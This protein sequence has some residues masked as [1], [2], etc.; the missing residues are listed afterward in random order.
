[1]ANRDKAQK[2][3]QLSKTAEAYRLSFVKNV[4][5]LVASGFARLD[6][7]KLVSSEEPDITGLLVDA[8]R[9]YVQSP[10][11][12][13]WAVH[14]AIHDDPPLSTGV[15]LGKRRPRVDIEFER[16]QAGK[17]P[18]FQFEAKRLYI[19][20]GVAEY[21]GKDGLGCF[22]SGRYAAGHPDAGMLGYVQSESV[23]AWTVKVQKGLDNDRRKFRIKVNGPIW[24]QSKFGSHSVYCSVH[25]RRSGP[26]SVYHSFLKCC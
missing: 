17:R 19:H 22:I 21:T 8:I 13:A 9:A 26:I 11:A 3:P 1:M 7:P 15:K 16:T 25:R 23:S 6:A 14:F 24:T 18:R 12:P 10:R 4:H 2:G 20:S 5:S